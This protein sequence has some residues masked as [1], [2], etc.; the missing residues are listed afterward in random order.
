MKQKLA[1]A[2]P[3]RAPANNAPAMPAAGAHSNERVNYRQEITA[4]NQPNTTTTAPPPPPEDKTDPMK[5]SRKTKQ[6]EVGLLD[7]RMEEIQRKQEEKTNQALDSWRGF[8]SINYGFSSGNVPQQPPPPP[9]KPPEEKRSVE[10]PKKVLSPVREKSP[11][12]EEPPA[13]QETPVKPKSP[14]REKTPTK[15]STLEKEKTPTRQA[16]PIRQQSPKKEES[17]VEHSPRPRTP[18]TPPPRR[19]RLNSTPPLMRENTPELYQKLTERAETPI[20]TPVP[21]PSPIH[22][23]VPTPTQRLASPISPRNARTPVFE[24]NRL[25]VS[26]NR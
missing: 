5:M 8:D 2:N 1:A 22:T 17:P 23:P 19:S 16:T 10:S 6:L 15:P 12:K 24:T 13:R 11:I 21:T 3:N 7:K 26:I 20:T 14:I 18:P 25:P 4:A 9:K